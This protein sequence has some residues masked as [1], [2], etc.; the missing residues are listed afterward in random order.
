MFRKRIKKQDYADNRIKRST[1]EKKRN[2]KFSIK[3]NK[4]FSKTLELHSLTKIK[5]EI[6]QL[7]EAYIMLSKKEPYIIT[8]ASSVIGSRKDQ[9]DSYYVTE[10]TPVSPFKITRSF[11]VVCDGIGGLEA[12]DRASL[13]AV[14]M[15]KLA[16]NKLPKKKLDIPRFYSEML[17]CIDYE[18]NHWTDLK[19]DKGSGTTLVS[20]LVENRRLYWASVGDS[21]IYMFQD[22]TLKKLTDKHN[23]KMYLDKLVSSGKITQRQAD[24]DPQ[25]DALLSY[26]GMGGV[27]YRDINSKPYA[28]RNGDLLVLCTDGITDTLTDKEIENIIRENIDDVY[29]CCKEI[30][31]AVSDKKIPTQD[32]ATVVIVNY[33]E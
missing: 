29:K 26:L 21:S 27:A 7:H 18:I 12:G 8:A 10:S 23:Y 5:N 3:F 22:N 30:T 9:Q 16:V 19:T 33:V 13:T 25:Q 31:S 17:D 32:N 15:M 1:K 11:A 20:V 28:M 4:R 14:S 2:L 6:P 24:E